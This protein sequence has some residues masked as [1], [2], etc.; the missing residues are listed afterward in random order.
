MRVVHI[1]TDGSVIDS[2]S[3]W[4][5]LMLWQKTSRIIAGY[6]GRKTSNQIEALAVLE[7]LARLDGKHRVFIY[8]DSAYV[9]HWLNKINETSV[10]KN[11]IWYTVN[12][13]IKLNNLTVTTSKVRGHSNNVFNNIVDCYARYC[14]ENIVSV[15]ETH[16]GLYRIY[17]KLNE[18]QRA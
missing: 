12:T 18:Q 10:G 5:A 7:S 3:G 14:A 4:A 2:V 9:I 6:T 17:A 8:T 16:S 1:W 11:T 15:E 13:I